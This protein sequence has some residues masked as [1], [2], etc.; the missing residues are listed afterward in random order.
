MDVSFWR[1]DLARIYS[2][3]KV[4]GLFE[5]EFRNKLFIEYTREQNHS[6]C[7]RTPETTVFLDH[8]TAFPPSINPDDPF[9]THAH[10]SR[11]K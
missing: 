7:R 4:S 2:I 10:K 9:S 3:S 5:T 8:C 6:Q 1:A 11:K